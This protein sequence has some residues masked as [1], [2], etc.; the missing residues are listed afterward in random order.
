VVGR[1]IGGAAD[2]GLLPQPTE[3]AGLAFCSAPRS[4]PGVTDARDE[5]TWI[6][7]FREDIGA[8][9]EDSRGEGDADAGSDTPG[10]SDGVADGRGRKSRIQ[11]K[12]HW[13]RIINATKAAIKGLHKA[14]R[15]DCGPK[16]IYWKWWRDR[17]ISIKKK[18]NYI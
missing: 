3:L 13:Y 10:T 12:Q 1:N 4:A 16:G 11:C 5:S 2:L 8:P 14:R 7:D 15:I 18:K 9:L 17:R 6:L